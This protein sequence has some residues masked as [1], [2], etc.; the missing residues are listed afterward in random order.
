MSDSR[1]RVNLTYSLLNDNQSKIFRKLTGYLRSGESILFEIKPNEVHI[2]QA[3]TDL[4]EQDL[5]FLASIL[6]DDE[7][8][9]AARFHF[10]HHQSRFIAAHGWLRIILEKYLNSAP[11]SL[12]LLNSAKGK[13]YLERTINNAKLHF[14]LSHSNDAALIGIALDRRIGVDIEHIRPLANME[15]IAG[16]YFSENEMVEIQNAPENV[17]TQVFFQYWTMKEAYLKATGTGLL[18]L[19]DMPVAQDQIDI[20][21][22][23]AIVID[24]SD[25]PWSIRPL[26]PTHGYSAAVAVDG[27]GSFASVLRQFSSGL[28][29]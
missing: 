6:S 27:N 24:A 3:R 1:C 16:R 11:D 23:T 10:H 19:Q 20:Y 22:Q 14:S 28:V 2:W 25:K 8:N 21:S 18:G 15:S 26:H 4:P 17:R 7:K 12:K 5:T 13:P 29:K 9:R